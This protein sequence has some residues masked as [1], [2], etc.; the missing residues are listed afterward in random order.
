VVLFFLVLCLSGCASQPPG[1]AV[2][3]GKIFAGRYINIR[4]PQ[5]EGWQLIHSSGSGMVFAKR[6]DAQASS[7]TASVNMFPLAPTTSEEGFETLIKE[8]VAKDTDPS[9]FDVQQQSLKYSAE[10]NYSCV[11]YQTVAKDRSPQGSATPLILEIDGLYCRH[12]IR[13]DTGFA[14]LYSYR[15]ASRYPALRSEAETFIQGVQVPEH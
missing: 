6:G 1:V 5:T 10:R 11:R 7:F 12:P 4:A 14:A 15:G 13:Q 8:A 3:P 9:R 2:T